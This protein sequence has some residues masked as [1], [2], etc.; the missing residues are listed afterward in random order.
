MAFKKITGNESESICDLKIQE[1]DGRLSEKWRV[2]EKDFPNVLKIL[3]EKRGWGIEIKTRK[4]K[5]D[6]DLEWAMK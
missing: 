6:K 5:K 2:I 4:E 1:G 3:N